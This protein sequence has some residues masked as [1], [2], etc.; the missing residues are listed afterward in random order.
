MADN[1]AEY[2]AKESDVVEQEGVAEGG[3]D[4]PSF[5]VCCSFTKQITRIFV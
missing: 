5:T 4:R 2:V 1:T 3:A